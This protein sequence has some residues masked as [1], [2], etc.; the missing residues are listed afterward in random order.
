MLHVRQEQIIGRG[1]FLLLAVYILY[2][3]LDL[4]LYPVQYMYMLKMCVL[5]CIPPL[6]VIS[7]NITLEHIIMLCTHHPSLA[8]PTSAMPCVC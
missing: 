2:P 6:Q 7:T 3:S 1:D 8:I 5:C 4:T